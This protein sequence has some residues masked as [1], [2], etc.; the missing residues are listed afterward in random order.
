MDI[1]DAVRTK[2]INIAKEVIG[3]IDHCKLWTR[4]TLNKYYRCNVDE[5]SQLCPR[6]NEDEESLAILEQNPPR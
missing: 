4:I 5:G 2:E 3:I 1:T 6:N